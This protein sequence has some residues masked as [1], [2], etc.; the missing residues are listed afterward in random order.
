MHRAP[1]RPP[2]PPP[3]Q[4]WRCDSHIRSIL[5]ILLIPSVRWWPM[6][7]PTTRH[8]PSAPLSASLLEKKRRGSNFILTRSI[9]ATAVGTGLWRSRSGG[10]GRGRWAV[11]VGRWEEDVYG[12]QCPWGDEDSKFPSPIDNNW[13]GEAARERWLG[14][15][16]GGRDVHCGTG[17]HGNEAH[18]ILVNTVAVGPTCN[19]R[20][21]SELTTNSKLYK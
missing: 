17:W 8:S 16:V 9:E 3:L 6:T 7:L 11:G 2:S 10:D 18:F 4:M 13:R 14:N 21:R 12:L 15:S 19:R 20:G 1:S 5:S